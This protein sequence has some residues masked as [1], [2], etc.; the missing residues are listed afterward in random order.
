MVISRIERGEVRLDLELLERIAIVFGLPLNVHLGRDPR[1]DVADA[2]HLAM[3]ELLLRL[4]R[5]NGLDRQLELPTR[6]TEPWR[7][8]DVVVASEPRRLAIA[9]E[10]WNTI[11][12]FGA[13]VR[14]SQ[15]KLAEL[16]NTT[17]GRWGADAQAALVWVVRDTGR[18][19]ALV[20]RYPEVFATRFPASSRAWVAALTASGPIPSEPGLV[21]CDVRR[22]R[23]YPWR[24]PV[25]QAA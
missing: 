20:A 13:A 23:L 17:V 9:I 8:I 25:R 24:R 14:S 10:C 3:Q 15:R 18:N 5:A 21:W 7:S 11:G 6:P 4:G 19:R 12:D 22:G 1:E 2:G 16:E